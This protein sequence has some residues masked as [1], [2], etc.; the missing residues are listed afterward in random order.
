MVTLRLVCRRTELPGGLAVETQATE[1]VTRVPVAVEMQPETEDRHRRE[2]PR[3]RRLRGRWRP[4]VQPLFLLVFVGLAMWRYLPVWDSPATKTLQGGDGD[5]AIFIWFLRWMP[6]ALEHGHDLLVSHH[7][8]YP[9][10][11]NLMWNTSLPLPGLLMAPVTDAWGPVLSFNLL[12]VIGYALSAWCAYLAIRRFVPGH[13]AAAVGGLVYGFTPAILSQSAHPHMTLAF[14]V[15]LMLLALHELLVRQRRSPWLVGAALGLMAGAQLLIGEELLAIATLVGFAMLLLL[16]A[17][18]LRRLWGR[19][20]HVL[21]GLLAAAV[22][23]AAVAVW[24]LSV[25]LTGPQHIEGDIHYRNRSNDLQGFVI[26]S[27]SQ[28][29]SPAAAVEQASRSGAANTGYLGLPLLLVL[30]A[31]GIRWRSNAVVRVALLLLVVSALLSL[32]PTLLVAGRDTGVWLPWAFFE[33]LPL[34]ASLI[35]SR[36]A[37][38]TALFAGLLVALFLHAVWG[39]GG[40]RRLAAVAVGLVALAPLWPLRTTPAWEV[41]T[42]AFFTGPAVRELPRDS[43]A[44]VLPFPNRA[45]SKPMIWQAEAGLWFRM[46]GGYFIGPQRDSDLPRFDANPTLASNDFQRIYQ[47]RPAPRLTAARRRLLAADFV[48]WRVGSVVVGPMPNQ[49]VMVGYLTELL[50]RPPQTVD[51]VQLWHD[52]VVVLEPQD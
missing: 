11:V 49:A 17:G 7:L 51:G 36:L 16:V 38:M 46:P 23:F 9:D 6:F 50:G 22:V 5:P 15:P 37:Q 8:N 40:W 26:P 4:P 24:P 45:T 32:G 10:G 21:K 48:R 47:G 29:I 20:A 2:E 18:N 52:P 33:R 41:G 35:P 3:R 27:S 43:V 31:I 1:T 13:L 39:E 44:L 28:A 25:L 42:P 30:G 12:L 19:A 14:L 34:L